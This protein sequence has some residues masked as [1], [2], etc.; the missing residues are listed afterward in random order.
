M[1]SKKLEVFLQMPEF[2]AFAV[3]IQLMSE[4]GLRELYD[5]SMAR[6]ALR[7]YQLEHLIQVKTATG[8]GKKV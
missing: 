5:P 4:K 6:V 3:L 1:R 7:V 2:E 8:P